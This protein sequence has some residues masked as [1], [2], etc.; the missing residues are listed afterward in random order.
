MSG[1]VKTYRQYLDG[2]FVEAASGATFPVLDPSTEEVIAR[3]P[4]SG[5]ADVERAVAA[6]RRAFDE[7]PWATTT[8]QER[9]RVLFRLAERVRRCH[10]ELAELESR[11]N[12]KPIVEA[13][14]D[15][16]DVATCFEH[17]GGLAT[18]LS[19]STHPVPAD[20]LSLSLKEPVGV[21]AQIIPWNHPLLMA[22]W[23]LG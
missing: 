19:G 8:A 17:Y 2:R 16:A 5:E 14:L 11:N 13:E 20:A 3:V 7:G 18:K 23:K 10:A 21:A 4:D 6:A 12:G 1:S 22:A 9:G 15:I